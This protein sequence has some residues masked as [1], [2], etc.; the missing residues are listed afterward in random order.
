MHLSS[1]H[2]NWVLLLMDQARTIVK[3]TTTELLHPK[4]GKPKSNT[5]KATDIQYH[6]PL[7]CVKE[8]HTQFCSQPN[9]VA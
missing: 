5:H 1:T 6:A 7:L 3:T 2:N 4:D 8:L 9:S